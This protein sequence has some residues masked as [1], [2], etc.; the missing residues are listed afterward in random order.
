MSEVETKSLSARAYEPL[1][2]GEAYPPLI[3][4]TSTV[5]ELTPRS[6]IWGVL[7]CVI[8]TVASA[9][10]GLKVGQVMEAAI[11]I[12]ILTIGLAAFI[13]DVRRCLKTSSSQV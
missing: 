6:L 10:S 5:P 1:E 12:S 13:N 8:F 2:P 4:A 9:Y 7:F 3:P 11:P